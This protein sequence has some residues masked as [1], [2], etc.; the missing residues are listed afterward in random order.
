MDYNSKQESL[1]KKQSAGGNECYTKDK[2]SCW[3]E[4][5][6]LAKQQQ[7]SLSTRDAFAAP[8]AAAYVESLLAEAPEVVTRL[9]GKLAIVT[10]VALDSV[11]YFIA[12]ELAMIGMH[13]VVCGKSIGS[14]KKSIA[15]M[16]AASTEKELIFYKT[17]YNLASMDSVQVAAEYC[18]CIANTK[19]GFNGQVH[20][21]VNQASVGTDQAKLTADGVE[22]NTGCNF[23]ATHYFTKLLLP[24]LTN[25]ATYSAE[26]EYKPRVVMAAGMSHALGRKF[27]P[28][29]LAEHP[30]EG[31]APEGYIVAQADGSIRKYEPACEEETALDDESGATAT[32]TAGMA[33]Y[34]NDFLLSN[35]IIKST[36]D[37]TATTPTTTVVDLAKVGTQV[38]RSKM[39]IVA[40]VQ[41]MA[42]LYPALNITSHHPGSMAALCQTYSIQYL[43]SFFRLSP[44]QGARA[45]LRAALD[46]AFDTE[47]D[48]QGG[49]YLHSDG[50]P[51]TPMEPN[52][53]N[54]HENGAWYSS[55]DYAA[56][57]YQAAENT[58]AKILVR[59]KARTLLSCFQS[60]Q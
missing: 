4:Y 3:K 14:L 45:A 40:D 37:S 59:E 50:N 51:W 15:R 54:C 26:Y 60:V 33:K 20:V 35:S 58:I 57:C 7:Q 39:A 48:L 44:S 2:E 12:Q 49:A 21:L 53:R 10:G 11:A 52:V 29:R 8:T 27:Q 38:G 42:R 43:K 22:Y 56:A 6:V 36:S 23:V 16:R 19:G 18:T 17:K 31:G 5:D 30:K 1:L 41:H 32:T 34:W 28:D 24:L 13:V 55:E 9:Q 47:P 25:A 46:P